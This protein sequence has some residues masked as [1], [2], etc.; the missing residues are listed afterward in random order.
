VNELAIADRV[1]IV[2]GATIMPRVRNDPLATAA[3]TSLLG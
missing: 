1:L 2:H 3:P